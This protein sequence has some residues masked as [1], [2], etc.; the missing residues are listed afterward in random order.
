MAERN[1]EEPGPTAVRLRDSLAV[2]ISVLVILVLF[3]AGTSAALVLGQLRSLQSSFEL[4]TEVYVV[5]NQKRAAAH[6]QAMRIG[7]SVA[8][9]QEQ[10]GNA[11]HEFPSLEDASRRRFAQALDER[12][13]LIREARV[14]I[15]EALG[16]A[17]RFGGPDGLRDLDDLAA[18]LDQLE[19]LVALDGLID[20]TDVLRDDRTQA[21][22]ERRFQVLADRT[23]TAIQTLQDEV[24][25]AQRRT[26]RFTLGLT[27]VVVLLGTVAAVGVALTL[28][29]LGRLTQ[30]VRKLG[31]G[32]WEQRID[33]GA[34]RRE[35]EVRALAREFNLMAEALEERERR[36]L[37][38]ERLAAAGQLAA[39]I[40]HE[41]RNP[42]SAVALN[43][44]LL[45]DELESAAPEAHRLLQKITA[46]VDRL[47]AVTED[48]LRFARRP[49]PEL[50][51]V[52]LLAQLRDLLEFLEGELT[53]A[54]IVVERRFP[55]AP[56]WVTAD[57][58]QLR[59]ALMNVLKNAQEAVL[60]TPAV[61]HEPR[62]NVAVEC[63][64]D[65]RT[66]VDSAMVSIQD[67]GAG[68]TGAAE[69][70]FEAFYTGK[71][72]G[73]GLGL[74]IVQQIVS[75][76]GGTIRVADTGPSGTRFEIR[77]PACD[78][79]KGAVTSQAA[80]TPHSSSVPS[81]STYP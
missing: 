59:Q 32:D 16:A 15:D 34:S 77:L 22:V 10:G 33:L 54:G 75:D 63:K 46:E 43:A 18:E 23:Q 35:D 53:T 40:T 6:L 72:R 24:G 71:A 30:G 47:T 28:R 2:R 55:E 17:D 74:P 45:E 14:P 51:P 12:A 60:E 1:T 21:Q 69:R 62:I 70:I 41:I 8:T 79:P 49:K 58:N 78:P 7:Q 57:Q 81:G 37:R 44:E 20:V 64:L 3:A 26:E 52:D 56:V 13:R 31:R 73:T 19:S 25:T 80:E 65:A 68:I 67:N 27:L 5:F 11:P 42:L 50:A 66:S 39:Q 4:L 38:G 76:H 48:Y 61:G 9:F 29:P 36:L